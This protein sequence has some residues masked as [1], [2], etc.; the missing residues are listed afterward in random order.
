[1]AGVGIFGSLKQPRMTRMNT[2]KK[3][4][5]K[6]TKEKERKTTKGKTVIIT[7]K[8]TKVTKGD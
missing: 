6:T 5:T 7:T 4:N 1:M 2:D 8:G 3:R